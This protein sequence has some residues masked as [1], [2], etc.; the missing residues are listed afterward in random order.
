M[1]AVRFYD[2][3]EF[4]RTEIGRYALCRETTA[5][6]DSLIES[7][8]E[9]IGDEISYKVCFDYLPFK[10]DGDNCLIGDIKIT[11]HTLAKHLE[12]CR[13]V[14]VFGATLGTAID[15]FILK[16]SNISPSRAFAIQAI[17]AER[18]EALCDDFCDDMR[19]EYGAIRPRFSPGF[20]DL[21][22]DVQRDIFSLLD[23]SKH[24]GIFLRESLIMSPSKSV[25]AFIGVE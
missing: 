16:Y 20:G 10:A 1:A 5:E 11:S 24:I 8:I 18:I 21:A 4:D 17:G 23:L 12:G 9:E 6:T 13:G 14:I 15:R 25:T 3:P 2:A 22:L 19:A 7:C